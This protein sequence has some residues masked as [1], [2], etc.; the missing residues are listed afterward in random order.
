ML[1]TIASAPLHPRAGVAVATM[2]GPSVRPVAT[3]VRVV[4]EQRPRLLVF[5]ADPGGLSPWRGLTPRRHARA[6]RVLD[7]RTTCLLWSPVCE[8]R[9]SAATMRRAMAAIAALARSWPAPP[10]RPW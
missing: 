2:R 6:L 7:Q 3:L 5:G 9:V 1:A 8:A 4:A 10:P